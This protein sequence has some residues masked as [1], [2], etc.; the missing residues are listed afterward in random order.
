VTSPDLTTFLIAALAVWRLAYL[1]V[2]DEGPFGLAL[3]LRGRIDPDQATW[4]GRGINCM[5]CVSFWLAWL[6][7]GV[8]FVPWGWIVVWGLALS[9]AVSLLK[10]WIERRR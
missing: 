4:I 8:L 6:I 2:Y 5:V 7:L 9:G 10:L 3:K 1:V